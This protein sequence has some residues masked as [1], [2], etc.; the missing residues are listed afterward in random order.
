MQVHQTS[1]RASLVASGLL[2]VVFA[3]PGLAQTPESP[4]VQCTLFGGCGGERVQGIWPM[5]NG[6][7]LICGETTS[8]VR[9]DLIPCVGVSRCINLPVPENPEANPYLSTI[10][11]PYDACL[12]G[13]E[14]D[15]YIAILDESM[16]DVKYFTYLGGGGDDRAYFAMQE[17]VDGPI[18]VCGF[19]TSV[20]LAAGLDFPWT[21][22]YRNPDCSSPNG[23]ADV[24]VAQFNATLDVL[25][26]STI[27]GG[28]GTENTRGTLWISGNFVYVSGSTLSGPALGSGKFKVSGTMPGPVG[29]ALTECNGLAAPQDAFIAKLRKTDGVVEWCR[30]LTGVASAGDSEDRAWANVRVGPAPDNFIYIAGCTSSSSFDLNN[31]I[32]NGAAVWGTRSGL[33]DAFIA[34]LSQSG[35]V[36]NVR[37]VGGSGIRLRGVQRL[38][39]TGPPRQ[40]SDSRSD[41][42]FRS[43]MHLFRTEQQT[44]Q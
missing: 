25:T 39:G 20:G 30:C 9:G 10:L 29:E 34:Q 38:S 43:A 15:A 41:A 32:D 12:S 40:A 6:D 21:T 27:I 16:S 28:M 26:T 37:Y 23:G 11:D 1:V 18:W 8:T 3:I 2:L 4:N 13:T 36:L 7:F 31:Q 42:L 17:V 35:G 22:C 24:F 19:T 14:R 33:K 5:P 44:Q